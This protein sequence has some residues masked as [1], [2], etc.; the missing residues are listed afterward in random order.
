[1]SWEVQSQPERRRTPATKDTLL[2]FAL[3]GIVG[4]VMLLAKLLLSDTSTS[5]VDL[6]GE[7]RQE[8][9]SV[10]PGDLKR[11][12]GRLVH[13][14]GTLK[15][16][17]EGEALSDSV[18]GISRPAL[19]LRRRVTFYQWVE[20][21][22]RTGSYGSGAT[23]VDH[24]EY[25]YEKKWVAAPVDSRRFHERAGHENR[26][27][28]DVTPRE[29]VP[30][31]ALGSA[32]MP[33]SLVGGL[34]ANQSVR[35][36]MDEAKTRRLEESLGIGTPRA[37]GVRL[38]WSPK[39]DQL[40]L[41]QDHRQPTI[42]DI[43]VEFLELPLD[44]KVTVMARVDGATF[45]P[46]VTKDGRK[47]WQMFPGAYSSDYFFG[48]ALAAHERQ[49]EENHSLYYLAIGM[50]AVGFFFL[51]L[52]LGT[53]KT[54]QGRRVP[55]PPRAS[56]EAEA[57]NAG[58]GVDESAR[59]TQAQPSGTNRRVPPPPRTSVEAEAG[60]AGSARRRVPPPPRG[61][62][63]GQ[64]SDAAIEGEA[65]RRLPPPPR[66]ISRAVD[67]PADDLRD[68]TSGNAATDTGDGNAADL[69]SDDLSVDAEGPR[70]PSVTA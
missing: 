15:R 18:F 53:Q 62:G 49:K 12:D 50:L 43:R 25:R 44:T 35:L 66:G 1:M 14:V 46:W 28:L 20:T 61:L 33:P 40:Y 6:I 69:Q 51:L 11:F 54:R 13:V 60:H 67:R 63:V 7:L 32:L 17:D 57:G 21:R 68:N 29:F 30:E 27:A 24:Y 5:Q 8:M 31:I 56:V 48:S 42:G 55:P 45:K 22:V 37:P 4:G 10:A 64:V 23:K 52:F 65:V 36:N 16:A 26:L 19:K 38:F 3:L 59:A 41:G 34:E 39:S 58:A 70:P 47:F 2:N 9:V